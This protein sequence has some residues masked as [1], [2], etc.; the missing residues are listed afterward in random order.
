[1][2]KNKASSIKAHAKRRF[3][4][5][6]DI[7]LTAQDCKSIINIIASSGG[8]TLVDKQSNTRSL[9]KVNYGGQNIIVVYDKLRKL[10][11]TAL[12]EDGPI[13]NNI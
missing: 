3:A 13:E 5:R 2:R 4:Q 9:H 7:E 6:F 11:V 8:T 10:L 12:Y 1:M